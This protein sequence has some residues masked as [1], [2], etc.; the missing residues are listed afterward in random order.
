MKRLLPKIVSVVVL[1]TSVAL[2]AE[3][4]AIQNLRQNIDIFTGVLED[5]LDIPQST[6]LFGMSIGG[7]DSTYLYGQGVVM[8]VRTPLANRRN[9]M[10]LS[11]LNASVQSLPSRPNPFIS[12]LSPTVPEIQN[13]LRI[14]VRTAQGETVDFYADMM[15][16]IAN[17]D[18]AIV[19]NSAIRQA[20]ESARS[21]R[22]MNTMDDAA[23]AEIRAEMATLREELQEHTDLLRQD[24][25]EFRTVP[26]QADAEVMIAMQ[27]SLEEFMAKIEPLKQQALAKA[28]ELRAQSE[29]AEKDYVI[30]WTADVSEFED[31]LYAAMCDYGSLLR[32]LPNQ[33]SI[34]IILTG[35]GQ[36]TDDG[37]HTDKLHVFNKADLVQCQNGELDLAGLRQRSAQY[38][39]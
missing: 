7:I 16:R 6:G 1:F 38:S 8:E 30:R 17:V 28:A 35:L 24:A 12:A 4:I 32:E 15:D 13:S 36:D 34:A 22:T 29:E 20:S 27:A 9:R 11:F 31:R 37:R 5:A 14:V 18:Y 19:I 2:S 23:Y 33:E 10:S 39:Y 26:G 21:L 25:A 3:E